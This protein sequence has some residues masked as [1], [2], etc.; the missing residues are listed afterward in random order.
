MLHIRVFRYLQSKKVGQHKK[1][2]RLKRATGWKIE[3]GDVKATRLSQLC[4]SQACGRVKG[5]LWRMHFCLPQ[6][7]TFSY[8]LN[9]HSS[10]IPS[11]VMNEVTIVLAPP[12][13]RMNYEG[14]DFQDQNRQWIDS[15]KRSW[16]VPWWRMLMETQSLWRAGGTA[17][18]FCA[19]PLTWMTLLERRLDLTSSK[20]R[21]TKLKL[22]PLYVPLFPG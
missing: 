13:V 10:F 17:H 15:G 20:F 2:E 19:F 21:F 3:F 7:W 6:L 14:C 18:S 11:M 9:N 8:L 16:W 22:L 1:T 4:R 12:N 5:K